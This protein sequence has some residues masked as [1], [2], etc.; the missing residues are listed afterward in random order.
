MESCE[1][2]NGNALHFTTNS[3]PFHHEFI[4][5][6]LFLFDVAVALGNIS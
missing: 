1:I 3:P 2:D 5:V 6:A 4:K